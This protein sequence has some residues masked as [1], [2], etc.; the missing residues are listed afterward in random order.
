MLSYYVEAI[1][2]L[3]KNS[4]AC[5]VNKT[6]KGEIHTEKDPCADPGYGSGS[7]SG[8]LRRREGTRGNQCP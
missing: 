8:R 4:Q 6:R 1:R 3:T 7:V 5:T 2:F